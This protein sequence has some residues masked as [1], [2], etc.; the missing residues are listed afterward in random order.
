MRISV[1]VP[2]PGLG[3]EVGVGDL[4]AHDAD[5]VALPLGERAVGLQRVLEP[6]DADDRQAT[7]RAGSRAGMNIA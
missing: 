7:P 3:G 4:A 2:G 5:Q 6:A 1:G